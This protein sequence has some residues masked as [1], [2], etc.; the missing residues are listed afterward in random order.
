MNEVIVEIIPWTLHQ[1]S[2]QQV[3]RS[4]EWWVAL[5]PIIQTF[6]EDVEK[7]K[8]GEF[9]VPESSRPAKKAKTE[10]CMIKFN[11]LD[12]DGMVIDA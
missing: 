11:K 7:A 1:W 12:E 6:W 4:E 3:R 10:Q 9:T 5:Q 8:R 2:E